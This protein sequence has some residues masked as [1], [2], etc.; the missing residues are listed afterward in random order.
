[1]PQ[2]CLQT[3][4]SLAKALLEELGCITDDVLETCLWESPK[5]QQQFQELRN[6]LHDLQKAMDVV[7]SI[8]TRAPGSLL[9]D[10]PETIELL[11]E[12]LL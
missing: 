4:R 12:W 5:S 8:L 9:S 11:T 6:K 1:M 7:K 2:I 3:T 10:R